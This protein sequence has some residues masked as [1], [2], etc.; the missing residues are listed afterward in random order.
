MA[1]IRK[2]GDRWRAEVERN[3]VRKSK[4]F[5]TKSE[6]LQWAQ[7]EE[8]EILA[9][10]DGGF[11]RKT[12]AD[13]IERYKTD[14]CPK[15]KGERAEK[16]R[17]DAFVR[18]FPKIAGKQLVDV[19]TSDMVEWR[20]ARLKV[21][22]PGSVQRHINLM[23]NVFRI[24]WK[25]WQWNDKNPFEGMK[26]PGDNPPRERIIQPLEVRRIVRWLGYRTGQRPVTKMQEAALAFMISLRTG[27]RAGE[28][29]SLT[30]D[31]VDLK[32]RVAKVPHK[33]QHLTGKLREVPLSRHAVRL[34][35]PV[36]APQIFTL[37]SASL[38]ALFRKA[39]AN[40]LI[41]DLH[42]HDARAS[43]LTRFSRKVDVLTLAKISGH[44][45]L[46]ILQQHYYRVTAEDIAKQLD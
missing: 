29:L 40:T 15:K 35:K 38:D 18:D 26:A 2:N 6:A 5:R 9:V 7:A 4:S 13:A 3:G 37:S 24:A 44:R 43:A 34:L 22:T 42:F 30:A 33:T 27:M 8:A 11:P 17:L 14:V 31:R 41:E 1:Y 32:K 25:E 28:V 46:K 45:D 16:L 36:M 23:S 10:K 19:K 39:K 12:L 20:D 21:V